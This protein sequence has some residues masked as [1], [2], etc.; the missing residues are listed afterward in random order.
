MFISNGIL[1]NHESIKVKT[2]FGIINTV[3]QKAI[4]IKKES[5][6]EFYIP[7]LK[8]YLDIGSA[9]DYI[10]AIWLT[11]QLGKSDDYV[12]A[13]GET[14]SIENIC[15]YVFSKLDLD[16]KK[17]I[18]T[19]F[20]STESLKLKGD[21]SKIKSLGWIPKYTFTETIDNIINH[22]KNL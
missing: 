14:H 4:E 20:N 9:E 21:I 7:N 1:Y 6:S 15:E 19:D 13:S 16:Y 17:Y 22:Y 2:L 12:I 18:K 8:V 5:I 10:E 11:L 3:V